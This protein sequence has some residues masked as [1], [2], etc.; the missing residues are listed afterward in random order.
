MDDVSGIDMSA[1]YFRGV[2][3]AWRTI[4]QTVKY[5]RGGDGDWKSVRKKRK[6]K[7]REG[8]KEGAKRNYE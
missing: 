8:K 2:S 4:L 6:E 1:C 3:F 5:A 7:K